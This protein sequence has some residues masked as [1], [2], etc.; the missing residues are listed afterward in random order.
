MHR[1]CN[2]IPSLFIKKPTRLL[3]ILDG[4]IRENEKDKLLLYSV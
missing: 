3:E 4:I 2:V 1:I